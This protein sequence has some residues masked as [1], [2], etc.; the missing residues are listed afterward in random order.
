M[1]IKIVCAGEEGFAKLYRKDV[2]EFLIGVDGGINSILRTGN[3]P[4]LAL[5]DFDSIDIRKVSAKCHTLRIYPQAK[6][7]GD[8]E[9][10]IQEIETWHAE[11]ISI[12]NAT[13][14]R[15]DHFLAAVNILIRYQH[16]PLEII[17]LR[18]WIC[19]IDDGYKP[20]KSEYRYCSFFAISEATVISLNGFKYELHDYALAPTD[21]LCLSNE[22]I[23]EAVVR[24]NKKLLLVQSF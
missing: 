23:Q 12:Y 17:D 11:R 14:G 5:G 7:Y 15:I 20:Q 16:L 9:L 22:I 10:A 1:I 6:D 18:N 21:N 3:I 19:L 4:D 13:G 2:D 8:L 24:T